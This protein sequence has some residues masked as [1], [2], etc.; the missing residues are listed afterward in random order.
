MEDQ[1]KEILIQIK[2]T[3]DDLDKQIA[4]A[5]KRLAE[6]REEKVKLDK[7]FAAGLVSK[8]GRDAELKVINDEMRK[9][10]VTVRVSEKTLSDYAKTEQQASQVLGQMRMNLAVVSESFGDLSAAQF[11]AA[12]GSQAVGERIQKLNNQLKEEA[13]AVDEVTA[14]EQKLASSLK[15]RAELIAELEEKLESLSDAERENAA[16]GG[17]LI[18]QIKDL[19]QQQDRAVSAIDRQKKGVKDFVREIDFLGFNIGET[20]D[21]F[22]NG[23]NAASVFSKAIGSGRLALIALAA[24]PIVLVLTALVTMLTKS[25]KG[26]DFLEKATSAVSA[27][28]SALTNKVIAVGEAI[29]GAFDNPRK[30]LGDLG[31]FLKNN[32]INRFTAISVILDGIRNKDLSKIGD[33]FLQMGT[34]AKNAY[35]NLKA[36]ADQGV[37]IAELNQEIRREE[38]ALNLERAKA[39][40]LIETNKKLSEDTTKSTAVRTA[41]ARK[42][43]QEE[44]RLQNKALDLQKKRIELAKLEAKTGQNTDK[45]KQKIAEAKAEYDQIIADSAE[46]QTELQNSIN[47]L[48]AEG[49][50]K[51]KEAAKQIADARVAEA[52]RALSVAKRNGEQTLDLEEE[53]LKRE[54]A[55]IKARAAAEKAGLDST[56]EGRAQAALIDERALT[57]SLER[58]KA[59]AERVQEVA[60]STREN[61]TAAQLALVLKGTEEELQLQKDALTIRLEREKAAAVDTIKNQKQQRAQLRRLDAQ[62]YADLELLDRNFKETQINQEAELNRLR[63][64]TRLDLSKGDIA[65]ER[66]VAADRID[67]EEQTQIKLLE[68]DRNYRLSQLS[69]LD[70]DRDARLKVET[71]YLAKLNAIQADAIAKRNEE[72]RKQREYSRTI[73]R[74]DLELQLGDVRAGSRKALEITLK[75]IELESKAKIEAAKNDAKVIKQI[76]EEADQQRKKATEEYNLS[77]EEAILEMA[78]TSASILSKVFETQTNRAIADLEAQQQAQLSSAALSA[79]AREK[80]ERDFAKRREKIEKDA[81]EKRRKIASIEN[82]I[83]TASAAV[84]AYAAAGPVAG[85]ILA[86][87]V[88]AVGLANQAV[89]DSQKF[90]RGG[91]VD[92]PSHEQGG[93]KYRVGNRVVEL[94]GGEVVINKRSSRRFLQELSAINVAGGGVP[95]VRNT[96]RISVPSQVRDL[97]HITPR[98]ALGGSIPDVDYRAQVMAYRE[99]LKDFKAVVSVESIDRVQQDVTRVQVSAND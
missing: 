99:A 13:T 76:Q 62:Y 67:L 22:Q 3:E 92:G 88:V 57:E 65:V 95:L 83:N 49:V 45:D 75:Q 78:G 40:R 5:K 63:L 41:A 15:A 31:E 59:F 72:E 33:G 29:V 98:F 36:A 68:L 70:K 81:A 6:L 20:A 50:Q 89:I 19:E 94:E 80:I 27:V 10:N 66:Q 11:R 16:V 86:G 85:A 87:L 8:S 26:M 43:Y 34:G 7:A 23:A 48:N 32:L 18:A 73:Q 2:I 25:Q 64:Q 90:T 71:D 60:L 91:I 97:T 54:L 46:K 35:T 17:K 9:L 52:E 21:S 93:V 47:S 44:D 96:P 53:I 56:K 14:K 4:N 30:A 38:T 24:V 28:F 84:K 1:P 39:N 55:A 69:N 61:A 77:L 51:A 58:T 79:D 42:A 82:V 12:D 74:K 37:K